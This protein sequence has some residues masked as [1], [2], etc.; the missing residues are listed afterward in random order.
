M[1]FARRHKK[2]QASHADD[3]LMTY[4]DMIT[5]LLCFFAVFMSV[6]LHQ[7]QE[8]RKIQVVR[9]IEEVPVQPDP[10]PVALPSI[11]P[12]VLDQMAT[13]EKIEPEKE[14]EKGDRITT[15]DM[16]SAAFFGSGSATLSEAGKSILLDVVGT[17]TTDQYKDYQITVE[18]HTDDSPIKTPQFPSNWEL[19]TARASAV[20]HYF[21]EQ[22]IAAQRLRAAGYADSFPKAPNRDFE[23]K[24]IP[25]NQAMNR[26]VVIKLEKVEK[27]G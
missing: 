3:W 23:G 27:S 7:K 16:N 11:V 15:L 17:L 10:V 22:G 24:P 9:V 1:K 19:S 21:L 4:A 2:R 25:E 14:K 8:H 6:S 26:R 12:P 18:G 5:L 20:V 13:K